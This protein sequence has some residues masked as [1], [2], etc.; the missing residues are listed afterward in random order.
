MSIYPKNSQELKD[1]PV[2]NT[3]MAFSLPKALMTVKR[4]ELVNGE[5]VLWGFL[6]PN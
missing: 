5:L 1:Y 4:R 2:A 3:T 6:A